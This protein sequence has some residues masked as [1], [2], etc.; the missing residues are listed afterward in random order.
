M[1]SNLN[2][3]TFRSLPDSSMNGDRYRV[4]LDVAEPNLRDIRDECQATDILNARVGPSI[5]QEAT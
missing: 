5:V 1:N 3:V 4:S 2:R